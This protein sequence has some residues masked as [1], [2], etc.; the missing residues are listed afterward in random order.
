MTDAFFAEHGYVDMSHG[1]FTVSADVI[2]DI[3]STVRNRAFLFA[4]YPDQNWLQN[5]R[6]L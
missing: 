4:Y 2:D 5:S 1:C 3:I 6:F